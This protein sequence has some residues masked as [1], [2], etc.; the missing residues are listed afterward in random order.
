MPSNTEH[1]LSWL[2]G[3][4][5]DQLTQSAT[6]CAN[7]GS[8]YKCGN[9]SHVLHSLERLLTDGGSWVQN[10][11]SHVLLVN[12]DQDMA[13]GDGGCDYVLLFK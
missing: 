5:H 7:I 8:F 13:G 10:E 11:Y 1:P 2:V 9:L 12:S 6:V 4:I 3:R